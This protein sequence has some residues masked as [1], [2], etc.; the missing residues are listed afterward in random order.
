MAVRLFRVA[1]GVL[2]HI[3]ACQFQRGPVTYVQSHCGV[4]AR[5]EIVSFENLSMRLEDVYMFPDICWDCKGI[6]TDDEDEK[7]SEPKGLKTLSKYLGF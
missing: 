5:L 4:E 1:N 2:K 6:A 7:P 3:M